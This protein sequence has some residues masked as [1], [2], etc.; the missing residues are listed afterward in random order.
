M[1]MNL[2]NLSVFHHD[3]DI[4]YLII[5]EII[6]ESQAELKVAFSLENLANWFFA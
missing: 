1:E 3:E 2:P 6:V 5:S 4:S